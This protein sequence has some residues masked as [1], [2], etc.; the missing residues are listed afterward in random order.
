MRARLDREVVEIGGADAVAFLHG[1][2]SQDVE[3]M[4]VSDARFSLALEPKGKV[5]A[6]FRLIRTDRGFLA[7]ID[8]GHAQELIDRLERF[9]LRTDVS[10]TVRDDLS[11]VGWRDGEHAEPADGDVVADF[12]WN[13]WTG[14]DLIGDSYGGE[15]TPDDEFEA[16]RI[17]SG[18]PHMG[19]EVTDE[20][21]PGE[22]TGVVDAAVDFDKGCYVGQELVARVDSRGG[23]VP[24]RLAALEGPEALPAGTR[25]SVDD[26]EVGWVTSSCADGEG[27]AMLGYVHRSVGDR[28][29]VSGDGVGVEVVPLT[30]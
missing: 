20:R 28:A 8:A 13:G 17:R 1:Q 12:A 30:P 23:N 6:F 29:Q 4:Q 18:F 2:L 25:L 16:A 10:F 27:A 11:V 19:A 5:V 15:P 24:R 9:R 3:S 21:I 14:V 22:I 7:D 26:S